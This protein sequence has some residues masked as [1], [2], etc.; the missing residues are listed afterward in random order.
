MSEPA[1]KIVEDGQEPQPVVIA[2]VEQPLKLDL[3]C[4]Q[5]PK[6]GFEGV[7]I[8]GD[9]AKY[10]QDLL[11][12]PWQ[13]EA[14]SVDELH[15]SHFIEHIPMGVDDTGKD[16]FFAFFDECHRILKPKGTMTV[17]W[18]ALQSVRAFQDP[19]HRRFIPAESMLY[20]SAE[21]RKLN[22]LDHYR[23]SCDF[24]VNVNPTVQQAEALRH[25]TVGS[26][27]MRELWNVAVDFHAVLTALKT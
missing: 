15:T 4:G 20:L 13:W 10:K 19:T 9:V 21:W 18:P 2:K 16:L 27:R 12:F 26:N 25:P 7:D 1:L 11:K 17:I 23:V 24:A 22:K 8:G 5:S 6:E 3:G 14:S